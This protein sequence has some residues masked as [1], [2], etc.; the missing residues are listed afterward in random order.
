MRTTGFTLIELMIVV[1]IIGVLASIAV[2][3]F[4]RMQVN[5]KEA[6]VKSNCHTVQIAAED[7][8]VQNEGVYAAGLGDALLNGN[9]IIDLLPQNQRLLNPFSHNRTEPIDGAAGN[10]GES[11]YAPVVDTDGTNIGYIIT[12][13]GSTRQ[14][15]QFTNF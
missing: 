15:C 11:G 3:N 4:I 12:G 13:W 5:A 8:S 6:A 1:V 14:V 9:T 10:T 7:F 2:P